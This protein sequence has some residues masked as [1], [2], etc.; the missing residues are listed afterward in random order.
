M[1]PKFEIFSDRI[2]ITSAGDLPEGLNEEEFFQ[3]FSV[4][5]TKEL[6]RIY[7]DLE[8]VEQLGSGIPR[9]LE[10]YSRSSFSF[11]D[12]FIRM[13]FPKSVV[14]VSSPMGG[15]IGG[16]MGGPMGG[17]IELT[18]R[19]KE[20]LNLIKEDNQL[21][22]RNLARYLAINVSAAQR[23][24]EALKEKGAIKREGGTRGKWT[25]HPDFL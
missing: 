10:Y 21:S 17:P 5:R 6:M 14:E 11:S 15:P 23:H 24:L 7:K 19:Q 18:A 12:N 8:L 3:G 25:I 22:R 16:P 2:E 1:P 13:V 9:I 20:V 4:P